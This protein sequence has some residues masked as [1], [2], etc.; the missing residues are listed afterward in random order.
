MGRVLAVIPARLGSTRFPG[1][2]LYQHKGKPLIYYVWSRV[3]CAK[4]IDRVLIAT[5]SKEIRQAAEDFGAE[6]VMTSKRHRTGSD[7][8]AEVAQQDRAGIIIN[9]Q[10]DTFGLQPTLLDRVIPTFQAD[11]SLQYATLARAINSD[12]DLFDPNLVKVVVADDGRALWFSRFPVPYLHSPGDQPRSEQFRF[13]GHLGIYFFRKRGLAD[14]ASWRQGRHEKAESL[15]QLRIMERGARMQVFL[16]RSRTISI[17]TPAD[18]R[19]IT[20]T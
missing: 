11:R 5:D 2:A 1:K 6:V 12:A 19:K 7:R 20:I 10:G 17:D 13:L 3:K 8:V 14:F 4:L 15:E 9:V 18:L 16:T